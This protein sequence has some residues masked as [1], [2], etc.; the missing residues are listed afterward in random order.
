MIFHKN[1]SHL[2]IIGA[3]ILFLALLFQSPIARADD[4]VRAAQSKLAALGYYKG[5]VDGSPGSVTSA[6]IRRFQ[7]AK[8]LKVTGVLNQQTLD[9]LGVKSAPPVPEYKKISTLFEGGPLAGKDSA[10]QVEAIRQTQR[11]LADAGFY[12]GPQNGLPGAA[13]AN[14]L[15]DWQAS[16]NLP[17]SGKLDAR[18]IT[19]LGIK[20]D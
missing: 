12:Q 1:I 18:T 20:L 3:G 8:S 17:K 4:A 14:A 7:L 19:A 15:K 6:A 5:K 2:R 13:L 10:S 11:A 16:L 9:A